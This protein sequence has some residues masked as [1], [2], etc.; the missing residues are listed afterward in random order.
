[1]A[2]VLGEANSPEPMPL[3]RMIRAKAQYG[4][5]TGSAMSPQNAAAAT[6]RPAVANGRGPNRPD[7]YPDT[8]P[9][10]RNPQVSGTMYMP[11]RH[12]QPG[13]GERGR[14]EPVGQVPRPRPGQQDPAGQGQHVDA[15][16]QRRDRDRIPVQRQPDPGQPDPQHELHPAPGDRAEQ[17]RR[18]SRRE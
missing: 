11:A 12:Q 14:P 6:S 9:A 17:A 1:M 13:G 8:G 4:K 16:P 3:Q 7:R 5:S 18:V 10:S 2:E 15:S